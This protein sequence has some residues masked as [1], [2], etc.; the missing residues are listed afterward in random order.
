MIAPLAAQETTSL[1]TFSSVAMTSGN[2]LYEIYQ[3]ILS[4]LIVSSLSMF[5][6]ASMAS[7]YA[8]ASPMYW[9]LKGSLYVPLIVRCV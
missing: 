9:L 2:G 4:Y 5:P 8:L 3:E 7:L 6:D 1:R